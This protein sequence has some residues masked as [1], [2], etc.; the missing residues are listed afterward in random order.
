M[1]NLKLSVWGDSLLQ[2]VL[3]DSCNDKY[4]TNGGIV[5]KLAKELDFEIKNFSRFGMHTDKAIK[6]YKE[7]IAI[8]I[9]K[10]FLTSPILN[11]YPLSP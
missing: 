1:K 2:G 4:Y 11:I 6:L 3:F 9:G 10:K 8:M 5:P 7:T